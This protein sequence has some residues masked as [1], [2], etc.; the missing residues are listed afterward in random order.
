MRSSILQWL[1]DNGD[2]VGR[3]GGLSLLTFI[4]SLVLIP[5]FVAGL[6]ADYFT[7]PRRLHDYAGDRHPFL[8]HLGIVLK[9]LL[10]V[11]L[12]G[13]GMAMLVLPGQGILTMLI[14]IVLLN[15]PGKRRLERRIA[16]QPQV[17]R[18]IDWVRA[19]ANQPPLLF[20]HN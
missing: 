10:G 5:V 3:L 17:R 15:F 20:D 8:H 9:N 6:P 18:G 14:G 11:M 7:H 16:S 4:V 2:L 12:V 1:N 13:A 19:R